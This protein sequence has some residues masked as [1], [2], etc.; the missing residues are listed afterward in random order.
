MYFFSFYTLLLTLYSLHKSRFLDIVNNP[1]ANLACAVC[2]V[3]VDILG[4]VVG[5][6]RS[7]NGLADKR[8]NMLKLEYLEALLT[9]LVA[10]RKVVM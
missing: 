4:N 2:V 8:A 9:K 10:I 7:L 3:L 1:L 6:E 5:I